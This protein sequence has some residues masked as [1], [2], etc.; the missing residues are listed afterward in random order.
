MKP[1]GT[2]NFQVTTVKWQIIRVTLK[3]LDQPG[4]DEEWH[5]LDSAA[6]DSVAVLLTKSSQS[7]QAQFVCWFTFVKA[8]NWAA[9]II[10]SENL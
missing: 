3:S 4:S 2:H 9:T 6:A 5:H 10:S 7:P 1:R 8:F